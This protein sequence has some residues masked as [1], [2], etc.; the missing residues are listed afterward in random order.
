MGILREHVLRRLVRL[1]SQDLSTIP[2]E[3]AKSEEM[4]DIVRICEIRV[5]GGGSVQSVDPFFVSLSL[6]VPKADRSPCL[7]AHGGG[8]A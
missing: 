8:K 5:I 6:P 4:E 1:L 3:G 2:T 7:R